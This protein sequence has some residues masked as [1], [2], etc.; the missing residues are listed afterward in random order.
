MSKFLSEIARVEHL[1]GISIRDYFGFGNHSQVGLK[2]FKGEES[3]DGCEH[4]IGEVNSKNELHG[5]GI[6]I[7][8]QNRSGILIDIDHYKK[9]ER[10]LGKY[11]HIFSD[12]EFVV[13]E[14]YLDY[15][16]TCIGGTSYKP[17]GTSQEL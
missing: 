8:H 10:A 2:Y 1:A 3:E 15:G 12:G 14:C 4:F 17:D 5:R 13:G 9:G 6:Y 11:I 7:Y 16:Q